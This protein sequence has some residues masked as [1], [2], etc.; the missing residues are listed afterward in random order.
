VQE[1]E[2]FEP[3][4]LV[5]ER[6]TETK[7]DGCISRKTNLLLVPKPSRRTSYSVGYGKSSKGKASWLTGKALYSS[8]RRNSQ[9]GKPRLGLFKLSNAMILESGP[10]F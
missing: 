10:R 5:Y 6:R 2:T 9:V 4:G 3:D 8:Q 7:G 1:I